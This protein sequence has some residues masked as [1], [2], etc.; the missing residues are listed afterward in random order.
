MSRGLH[1]LPLEKPIYEI[2]DRIA[3]L[4]AAPLGALQQEEVR[5]LKR[6]L[7]RVA[8]RLTLGRLQ[9]ALWL[10]FVVSRLKLGVPTGG[11][12]ARGGGAYRC[13]VLRLGRRGRG[14]LFG[15]SGGSAAFTLSIQ[16]PAFR[17]PPAPLPPAPSG[18][19]RLPPAPF[20]SLP[21][22]LLRPHPATVR[23]PPGSCGP[24][25]PPSGS[26]RP[27]PA[28]SGP[29]PS[30]SARLLR[31]VVARGKA[32][33][34]GR[35][36]GWRRWRQ[37]AAEGA[38]APAQPAQLELPKGLRLRQVPACILDEHV[39]EHFATEPPLVEA[40]KS[41]CHWEVFS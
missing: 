3:A 1:R 39:A 23:P 18:S 8:L 4:E 20:G 5:R 30:G 13:F 40:K 7:V 32:L 24:L 35:A 28:S 33:R 15:R 31:R 21:S 26:F 22:L 14:T 19:L 12:V 6:E 10:K 27:A 11:L 37:G 9:A 36:A 41:F 16:L 29:A 2:E 38:A 25:W 34:A 17:L